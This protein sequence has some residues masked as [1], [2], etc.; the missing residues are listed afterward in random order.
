MLWSR[1]KSAA[2][3]KNQ[4]LAVQ[5]MAI[6]TELSQ[7]LLT[8]QTHL[9]YAEPTIK[10]FVSSFCINRLKGSEMD[11]LSCFLSKHVVQKFGKMNSTEQSMPY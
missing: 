5:P 4:T 8:L 7:L 6:L 3:A 11:L 10:S 2:S 9:N 1:A